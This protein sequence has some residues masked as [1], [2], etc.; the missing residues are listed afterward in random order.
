MKRPRLGRDEACREALERGESTGIPQRVVE[1]VGGG[2]VIVPDP[3][4]PSDT[5]YAITY[6]PAPTKAEPTTLLSAAAEAARARRPKWR[7]QH[8]PWCSAIT[9]CHSNTKRE[10]R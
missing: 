3:T 7:D 9:P 4:L 8:E 5:L 1:T 2:H 6:R 10:A